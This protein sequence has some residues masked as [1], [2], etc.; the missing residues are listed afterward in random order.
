MTCCTDEVIQLVQYDTKPSLQLVVYDAL[1]NRAYDFSDVGTNVFFILRKKGTKDAKESLLT[2]KLPGTV[3]ADG[4]VTFPPAFSVPGSGGRVE[5]HWS[6]T[7]LDTAGQFEGELQVEWSDGTQQ[8][9]PD[10][11]SL[12]VQPAWGPAP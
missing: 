2:Q 12:A 3:A 5:V 9:T 11:M 7:A 10:K 1:N 8:T 6:P 4:T